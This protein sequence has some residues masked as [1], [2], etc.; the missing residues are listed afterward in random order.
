MTNVQTYSIQNHDE[1]RSLQHYV[2]KRDVALKFETIEIVFLKNRKRLDL[3]C[4]GLVSRVS[5]RL[6]CLIGEKNDLFTF[7]LFFFTRS[8]HIFTARGEA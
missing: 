6:I 5:L 8:F 2:L 7:M 1:K 3:I 4:V